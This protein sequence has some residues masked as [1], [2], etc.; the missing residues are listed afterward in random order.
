MKKNLISIFVALSALVACNKDNAVSTL[1]QEEPNVSEVIPLEDAITNL[2]KTMNRIYGETKAQSSLYNIDIIGNHDLKLATKSESINIP[3][4]LIYLV[5][6][7]DNR[8]FAILSANRQLNEDIYCITESG[9]ISTDNLRQTLNE[10]ELSYP[11]NITDDEDVRFIEMG[12][13]FVTHIIM[14]TIIADLSDDVLYSKIET[15]STFNKSETAYGPWLKTKWTQT[16]P[17]NDLIDQTPKNENGD[18]DWPCGCTTIAAAQIINYHRLP[19]H[20]QF[21][22]VECH[23]DTLSTVY[24]YLKPTD[25]GSQLAQKQAANFLYVIGSKDYCNTEYTESSAG[26]Y[27]LDAK[28]AFKKVGFS[29]LNRRI[30]CTKND[31]NRIIEHVQKKKP[32]IM[33]G[34]TTKK[35]GNYGH[36]WVVDGVDGDYLHI[37]WGW[38]GDCDG[39]FKKGSFVTKE[40]QQDSEYDKDTYPNKDRNYSITFRY[41]TYT[42]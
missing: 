7:N 6:F 9:H 12:P 21:N 33:S 42:I 14:E 23:W 30:G 25:A 8:G 20:P 2:N 15:K 34:F 37:N 19:V 27:V 39:Y 32:I 35:E 13:D 17:F 22:G 18:S 28:R 11:S 26:A 5:N 3:D 16:G 36:T 10:I 29:N 24:N 41:V 38:N 40:T 1:V 31:L 4:T